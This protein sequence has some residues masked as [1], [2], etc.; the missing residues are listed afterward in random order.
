MFDLNTF[1]ISKFDNKVSIQEAFPELRAYTEYHHIGHR[2]WKVAILLTDMG[3]PFIKIKDNNHK[4]DE[5]FRTLKIDKTK[6]GGKRIYEEAINYLPS[7]VMD[8]CSFIIMYQNNHDFANWFEQNI[9]YYNLLK[10]LR[11]PQ[12]E[13]E[14][15]DRY[16]VNKMQ[17][18]DRIDKLSERLK[19]LELQ[20]F[21]TNEMK[22]AAFRSQFRLRKNYAEKYAMGGQVE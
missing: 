20:L 17:Y 4:L 21:A 12:K 19:K 9:I 7:N 22:A 6:G 11:E 13:G 2:E 16:F 15:E 5:I 14:D 8:A 1:D 10:K 18:S 3:S